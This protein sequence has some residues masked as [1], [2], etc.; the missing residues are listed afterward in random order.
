M[1]WNQESGF[2]YW[3]PRYETE[4]LV[5]TPRRGNPEIVL[6]QQFQIWNITLKELCLVT[7]GVAIMK[8]TYI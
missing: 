4:P 5:P 6:R 2:A 3:Q 1:T 8:E 7:A